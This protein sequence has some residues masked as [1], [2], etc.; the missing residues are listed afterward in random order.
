MN[1][2]GEPGALLSVTEML[3]EPQDTW[4]CDAQGNRYTS[5]FRCIAV[6]A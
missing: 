4:L 1:E 2:Q 5:E 3:P 6:E